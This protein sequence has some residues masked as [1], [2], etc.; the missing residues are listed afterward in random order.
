MAASHEIQY[1]LGANSPAGF[2][3]LY[4][5][6]LSPETA[7]AIYIL[8]GGPGCGKSTLMRRVAQQAAQAGETVE[9]IL[10]SADPDSLDGVVLP[11]LGAALVDGTAPHVV[12]PKYPGAVEQYVNLGNCYDRAGLRAIPGQDFDVHGRLQG[13][14][15]AGLPL[16]GRR[17]RDPDR[18]P[19][20]AGRPRP[21]GEAGRPRPRDPL[22]G[23]EAQALRPLRPG[24]AAV[25]GRRL[26]QGA[27][28]PVPDGPRPVH[29]DL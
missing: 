15:S 22:P 5:E 20:H 27:H 24:K 21:G 17:R 4:S 10:C 29:P 23:A 28:H 9:Y 18:R 6:L 7:N 26:P 1:F 14:L 25:P 12:E 19:H 11:R 13:A 2:Y 8:K 16:S 3:S